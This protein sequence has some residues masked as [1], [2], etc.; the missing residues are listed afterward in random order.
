[1]QTNS[2]RIEMKSFGLLS[3]FTDYHF[4]NC[5]SEKIPHSDL[6]DLFDVI[7]YIGKEKREN[8]KMDSTTTWALLNNFQQALI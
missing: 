4:S 7:P 1:M 5:S 8:S 3:S 6:N 2:H